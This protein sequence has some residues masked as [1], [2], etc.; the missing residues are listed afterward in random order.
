MEKPEKINPSSPTFS[1]FPVSP[2]FQKIKS[3]DVLIVV[4]YSKRRRTLNSDEIDP[5]RDA[6]L[7]WLLQLVEIRDPKTLDE[8]Q[9]LYRFVY[10]TQRY[11]RGRSVYPPHGTWEELIANLGVKED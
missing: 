8:A 3:L 1:G 7:G 2:M 6:A 10:R 5:T 4:S 9:A 11:M